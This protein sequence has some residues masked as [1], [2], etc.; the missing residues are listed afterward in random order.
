M[1]AVKAGRRL[2]AGD[3]IL[4]RETHGGDPKRRGRDRKWRRAVGTAP[5]RQER[6]FAGS[7]GVRMRKPKLGEVKE[8]T[9]LHTAKTGP[10]EAEASKVKF[11]RGYRLLLPNRT[12]LKPASCPNSERTTEN[13]YC[14]SDSL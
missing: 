14:S 9:Q 1:A 2:G 8:V 4:E 5:G 11:K 3:K 12:P 10:L 7:R 6:A 13:K